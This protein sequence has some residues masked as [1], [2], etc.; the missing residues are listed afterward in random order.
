MGTI[1]AIM[2]LIYGSN[3]L[4]YEV[5]EKKM[6]SFLRGLVLSSSGMGAEDVVNTAYNQ[7]IDIINVVMPILIAVILVFGLIYGIILGVQF[8]KAE[9]TEQR[10]KAKQ[11]LINVIIGVVVAA[12]LMAIIYAILPSVVEGAFTQD[13]THA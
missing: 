11:R 3:S 2:Q 10:D 4:K 13:I 1:N 8:A 5:E 9:D 6:M 7:F 12:V